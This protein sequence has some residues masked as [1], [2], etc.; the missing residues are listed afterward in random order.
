MP[1][2]HHFL[3]LYV[4]ITKTLQQQ[5]AGELDEILEFDSLELTMRAPHFG[6]LI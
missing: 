3:F 5:M 2:C 1:G 4:S 6:V